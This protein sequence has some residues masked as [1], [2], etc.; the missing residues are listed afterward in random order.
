[1]NIKQA[2]RIAFSF[3]TKCCICIVAA[4]AI[5]VNVLA[6][7]QAPELAVL[8]LPPERGSTLGRVVT[9]HDGN[10]VAFT[11]QRAE[12]QGLPQLPEWPPQVVVIDRRAGTV[13]LA[14][15]TVGGGFQNEP[16][17]TRSGTRFL[18]MSRDGR[19]VTFTSRATNLHPAASTVERDYT[20]LYDRS[21]RTVHVM[22]ADHPG[23][24]GGTVDGNGRVVTLI[25]YGPAIGLPEPQAGLCLRR[26]SDMSLQL[27]IRL[28]TLFAGIE[29]NTPITI[30]ANGTHLMF[31]YGGPSIVPGD[32]APFAGSGLYV[33]EIATGALERIAS[34]ADG[35]P[36]NGVSGA[37]S[38]ALSADGDMVAFDTFATN[39]IPGV[40]TFSSVI[41]K[42]RS[43][44][45]LR[46]VSS[47]F[48][49]GVDGVTMSADG[50]RLYYVDYGFYGP[51][52]LGRVHDWEINASRAAAVGPSN[53]TRGVLC[54]SAPF[55]AN[56][57]PPMDQSGAISGDGR[58]IYYALIE[59]A[60][61][62]GACDL[63]TR[64]LGPVPA[65]PVS[66][67][68]PGSA[69]IA[70]LGLMMLLAPAAALR[71][72]AR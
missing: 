31:R 26:V 34:A 14:S 63:Y 1:M 18:S 41:M 43:T 60:P 67:P 11:V 30:S 33:A 50:R 71:R 17:V 5:N 62:V 52:Q 37:K 59:P 64:R 49:I 47:A 44:G 65:P 2:K 23:R 13:E 72:T 10:V 54:G 61:G 53:P 4:T 45:T 69:W 66:V 46:R 40:A 27:V 39:L 12:F 36:A 29:D 70:L 21:T 25:C 55:F 35:T 3:A 48:S 20:Y 68:A 28:P 6:S 58:A 19:Y 22:N 57:P 24:S 9:S 56:D 15:R 42:Q 32:P 7:D 16:G 51:S 38:F 8:R